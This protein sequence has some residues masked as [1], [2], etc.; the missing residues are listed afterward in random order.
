M[1]GV[2]MEESFISMM[3]NPK[4]VISI[5]TVLGSASVAYWQFKSKVVG[6]F[7]LLEV[8]LLHRFDNVEKDLGEVR[9]SIK[10]L[11]EK[12]D[13]MEQRERLKADRKEKFEDALAQAIQFYP[14]EQLKRF[15]IEYVEAFAKTTLDS[16]DRISPENVD[17]IGDAAEVKRKAIFDVAES[18]LGKS[19]AGAFMIWNNEQTDIYKDHIR[20]IIMDHA[21]DKKNRLFIA[22]LKYIHD[23]LSYMLK[24]YHE[25]EVSNAEQK[26]IFTRV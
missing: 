8:K 9:K 25:M 12:Q 18:C 26:R 5:I 17:E 15:A 11:E 4:I 1:Q 23:V 13:I 2:D 16:I 21:N 24:L 20:G 19:Y 14:C 22:S 7:Q 3:L 6:G 10:V